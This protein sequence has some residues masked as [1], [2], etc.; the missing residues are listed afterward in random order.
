MVRGFL[1]RPA[2][3]QAEEGTAQA[4]PTVWTTAILCLTQKA[5]AVIPDGVIPG[6][7][8]ANPEFL[9][10]TPRGTL[11]ACPAQATTDVKRRVRTHPYASGR[12]S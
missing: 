1:A 5:G 6:A 2:D 9:S 7:A 8:I 3:F 12:C 10:R 4:V 11:E